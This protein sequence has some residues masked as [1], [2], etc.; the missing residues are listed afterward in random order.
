MRYDPHSRS[1]EGGGA[2]E[3]E[4]V[5][6]VAPEEE[7]STL[8]SPSQLRSVEARL[9]FGIPERLGP[10]KIIE[11]LGEGGMARVYRGNQT[12]PVRREVAVK[13]VKLGLDTRDVIARF[14]GERS[15]LGLMDHP[16]IAKIFGSGV[17]E[18]GLPYFAMEYVKGIPITEYCDRH[19][20]GVDG[21]LD[22]IK[23]TC[24]AIQHAHQ[25]SVVHRD[26]K[27]SN[28]LVTD[29]GGEPVPKVIDFG[30]AKAIRGMRLTEDTHVTM[31]G[32]VM[33]TPEYMSP[34]QADPSALDVDTRS[35]VYSI[36][37]ILYRL[38]AGVHPVDLRDLEDCDRG[39]IL[40]AVRHRVL[41][42]E[43]PP[44]S[45]RLELE[46]A[47]AVETAKR[48]GS[49]VLPLLRALRG[50]LDWIVMKALE[51]DRGRRYANASDIASDI[52]RHRNDEPVSAGPPSRSYRWRKFIRKN[53]GV[54]TALLFVG[55]VLLAG[56][57]TGTLFFLQAR[58]ALEEREQVLVEKEAALRR[59]ETRRIEAERERSR[60][61][62]AEARER[63]ERERAQAAEKR[64]RR[65]R[66]LAERHRDE[67]MRLADLKR[68]DEYRAQAES[69]W[70]A[71]PDLV[72]RLENWLTNAKEL[73]GRESDHREALVSLRR[74]AAILP[75]SELPGGLSQA[76]RDGENAGGENGDGEGLSP[77]RFADAETQWRHDGLEELV[78]GLARF[79]GRGGLIRR[80]E[81]QLLFSRCVYE[82]SVRAYG[83][84]WEEA[85]ADI[86]D[87]SKAPAYQGLEIAPQI[88]LVPL[89][90][91]P[92]SGLWEFGHLQ[93]GDIAERGEDGALILTRTT[94]L[95]F[96][97]I[98]GGTFWMG[99]QGEDGSGRN[100]DPRELLG[101]EAPVHEVTL[102]PFFV[103]KYEVTQGQWERFTGTNPSHYT[104][105]RWVRRTGLHPVEQ[106]S[107]NDGRR[108]LGKLG[109]LLPTEA[110]WEYAARA[111]TESVWWTGEERESL[112]GAANFADRAGAKAGFTWTDIRDWP[113]FDDGFPVHSPVGTFRAN[114]FGLHDICGNVWEWCRDGHRSYTVPGREGDGFRETAESS[115]YYVLRGGSFA[116]SCLLAR[117]GVRLGVGGD[118]RDT[119]VGVRPVRSLAPPPGE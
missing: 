35:D 116:T 24:L 117:S 80:M 101:D 51:K 15:A 81:T 91:D 115:R 77:R 34:E 69:L 31:V 64:E 5:R 113:D 7:H 37:V 14:E 12:D 73:A 21:R 100:Y 88:G 79:A 3:E 97:L 4:R 43:P 38:L 8:R 66:E 46:S 109:L 22:L 1:E 32:A 72:P 28:I 105:R 48:V 60:A 49:E 52:D 47:L 6:R 85:V 76:N 39:L 96:V 25:K 84:E 58:H 107:W 67:V 55:I 59:E 103:S 44:P 119:N 26:L 83:P 68:L 13:V 61:E 102:E 114:R 111:G 74:R 62:T 53:R 33:G 57:G 10:Y 70:P 36:G 42:E 86:R 118:F 90:R 112:I 93:T 27:P 40:E 2:P 23:K 63:G 65:Q 17:T 110:Q 89:G 41:Q 71:H 108:V 92:E 16:N 11:L 94:G 29:E 56:G 45:R 98:P 18:D 106:V 87:R 50:D 20:L 19:R 78:E 95:V 99:T 82:E 104:S 9:D 54:V 30:L 75:G